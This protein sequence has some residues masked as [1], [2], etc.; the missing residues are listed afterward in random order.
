MKLIVGLGNPGREYENTRHNIGFHY[1]DLI[2]KSLGITNYHEKFNGYYQKV[3]I[4]DEDIIFFDYLVKKSGSEKVCKPNY[5]NK[6]AL[7]KG[8]GLLSCQL[9]KRELLESMGGF[10]LRFKILSGLEFDL[11]A[12]KQNYAKIKYVDKTVTVVEKFSGKELSPKRIKRFV[13]EKTV[14]NKNYFSKIEVFLF[15]LLENFC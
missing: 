10:D 2:T 4:L 13:K 12:I 9:I 7:F 15:K 6:S 3:K 14:L 8:E 11:R 1:L 5:N